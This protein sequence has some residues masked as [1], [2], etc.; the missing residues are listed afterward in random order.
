MPG[1]CLVQTFE[2]GPAGWMRWGSALTLDEVQGGGSFKALEHSRAKSP[3]L[4]YITSRSPWWIDYNHAPPTA[5]GIG[6]G[7]GY[8]HMLFVYLTSGPILES[9]SEVCFARAQAHL[10]SITRH[11]D[12]VL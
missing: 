2:D 11:D 7:A 12:A 5:A 3:S 10:N 8:M 6:N 4:S 9:D 1:Q